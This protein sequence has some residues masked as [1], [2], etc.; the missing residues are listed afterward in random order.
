M[1]DIV[2]RDGVRIPYTVDGDGLGPH[3]VFAHGL[4]GLASL[5]RVTLAP[6]VADVPS[7]FE[8]LP[9]P[10][11]V[12]GWDGDAIHPLQTAKEVAA[13]AGVDLI[14]A[15]A[16]MIQADRPAMGRLLA[17]ALAKLV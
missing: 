4:M 15:D 16:L 1:S 2:E 12:A 14:E 5:D 17:G 13:A 6:L 10:V 7:G 11:I 8:G 3:L 9:F